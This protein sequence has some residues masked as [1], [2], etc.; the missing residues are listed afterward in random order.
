MKRYLRADTR[1]VLSNANDAI[2]RGEAPRRGQIF[3]LC[4]GCPECV[5]PRHKRAL[6]K[7]LQGSRGR[8]QEALPGYAA[9]GQKRRDLRFELDSLCHRIQAQRLAERD[10]RARKLRTVIGIGQESDE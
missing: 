10:D 6:G 1:A 5:S 9:Q 3:A 4:L 2:E 8:K 7:L